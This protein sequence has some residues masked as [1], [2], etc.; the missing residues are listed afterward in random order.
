M[1]TLVAGT[2]VGEAGT[3][4]GLPV[5]GTTV[6]V[7]RLFAAEAGTQAVSRSKP[8]KRKGSTFMKDLDWVLL[9]INILRF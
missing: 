8:V 9:Y 7:G 4:V 5:A 1:G 2:G 3:R 6:L